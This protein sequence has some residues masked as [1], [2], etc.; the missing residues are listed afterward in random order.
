MLRK[1]QVSA[2]FAQTNFNMTSYLQIENLTKSYGTFTMFE[3]ISF[4]LAKDQKIALIARNGT[5]KTTLF[6]ILCG[7]DSPDSGSLT[8]HKD[9]SIGFLE[10]DPRYSPDKTVIEQV[11]TSSAQVVHVIE[12]YEKALVSHDRDRLN[13]AIEQMEL[14]EGWDYEA[15]IK[16]ILGK[17]KITGFDQPMR[18][19]SGGQRKRV[20]LANALINNPDLLILDEPTNHLDLE[21]IEW[22]EEYLENGNFTLLMVTHDRY[23]LES[24]CNEIVE[25]DNKNLYFYKGN[26]SYYLEKRTERLENETVNVDKARNLMRSELDWIRR[27]PKAR[28][29]KAKYRV[30][31]FEDLKEKA[32]ASRLEKN[33]NINFKST[34]LGS[35]IIEISGLTKSFDGLKL[36]NDFSYKF[37]RFEKVGIVGNNGTG[38]TT[39]LNLLTGDIK[40][41]SGIID[42]GETLSI[43]YYKQDGLQFDENMRVIDV[44]TSV[45]EI[46]TTSN[47]GSMGVSAFLNYFLFPP[48]VQYS[49]VYK[50]S[51]GEKRRL[52]LMTVLM[53]N[54]NFL[55]L[56]EP[57]NDLDLA[58]LNVLEDYLLNFQGC[59]IIVSHDRYFMDKLVD[60]IFVF[61]GDGVIKDF[62]GNYSDYRSYSLM[63]EKEQR[64][65]EKEEKKITGTI[66]KPKKGSI[67]K[68][69]YKEQRE[70]EQL[71]NEIEGLESEK[72]SIEIELSSGK[73]N[74]NELTKKSSRHAGLIELID[75][76]SERW[77]ELSEL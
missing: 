23:F 13:K 44:A 7:K 11:L 61:E 25:L 20:A 77:M 14:Q 12:E 54:P 49:Y 50:L 42:T 29:T 58:T 36:V 72:K 10:Q 48:E 43:G 15:K 3:N 76:K 65:I 33:V 56:D 26:Y 69:N 75:N 16:Q 51:G 64:A 27:M 21:M 62:P 63:K 74:G 57:T 47:G 5:G 30:N 59:T 60:H 22:L 1:S 19:L 68:L 40:P 18:N 35:K 70:L 37:S 41:D 38:K 67:K 4:Q 73:L 8:F 71:T 46:V 34:R 66:E 52:Y 17:L 39:F 28:G 9:I 45:A 2:K 6:N 31:A 53:R 55:I 32:S 24:V